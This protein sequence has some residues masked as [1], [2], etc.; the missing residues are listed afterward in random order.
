MLEELTKT[1][2]QTIAQAQRDKADAEVQLQLQEKE[3]TAKL[4]AMESDSKI[5]ADLEKNLRDKIEK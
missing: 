5:K 2:Q 4:I 3:H 1:L